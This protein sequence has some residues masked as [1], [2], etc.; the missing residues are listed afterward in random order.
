MYFLSSVI[1]QH[2][3]DHVTFTSS[4]AF[5]S[6]FVCVFIYLPGSFSEYFFSGVRN[7]LA[8]INALSGIWNFSLRIRN[9]ATVKLKSRAS[10]LFIHDV[11]INNE[12]ERFVSTCAIH[13]YRSIIVN[14]QYLL[15]N[16][17]FFKAICFLKNVVFPCCLWL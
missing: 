8:D 15:G 6:L 9:L 16:K 5:A 12:K 7:L 4:I 1:P 10:L 2:F 3:T 14:I 11:L 17:I 13:S